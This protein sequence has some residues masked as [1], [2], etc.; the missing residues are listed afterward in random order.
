M[1]PNDGSEIIVRGIKQ[2]VI[3]YLIPKNDGDKLIIDLPEIIHEEVDKW[4]NGGKED[5][6]LSTMQ[7]RFTFKDAMADRQTIGVN[8]YGIPSRNLEVCYSV[9]LFGFHR[10]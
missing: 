1:I 2:R 3:Y 7:R 8:R 10:R 9:L 4:I 6:Y 5:I